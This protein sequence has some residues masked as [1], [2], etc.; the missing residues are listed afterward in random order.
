VTRVDKEV[1]KKLINEAEEALDEIRKILAIELSS[2]VSNRSFRFSKCCVIMVVEALADWLWLYW[3][4]I[5]G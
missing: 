2:F 1:I 3:R 5:W 4:K